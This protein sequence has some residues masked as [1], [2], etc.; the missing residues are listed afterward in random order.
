MSRSTTDKIGVDSSS[1][2]ADT[3]DRYRVLASEDR[4]LA[5]NAL[6][7][8]SS[9]SLDALA[10]EVAAE[11][12]DGSTVERVK[13]ALVHQHLP[14]LENA[15]VAE[16]DRENKRITHSEPALDELLNVL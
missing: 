2:R 14:V 11:K 8:T 3:D 6:E 5:L 4:Q 1:T 13:I 9:V 12:R 16:Y 15:G 10:E 7:G